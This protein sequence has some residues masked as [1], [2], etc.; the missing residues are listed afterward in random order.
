[1]KQVV[2][3]FYVYELDEDHVITERISFFD[4]ERP[5]KLDIPGWKGWLDELVM[6]GKHPF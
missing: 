2:Q 1:M 3:H 6:S 5:D 4:G